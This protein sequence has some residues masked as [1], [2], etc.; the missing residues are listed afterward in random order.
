MAIECGILNRLRGTGVIKYFGT[1][2]VDEIKI[3]KLIIPKMEVEVKLVWNHIYGLYLALVFGLLAMNVWAGLAVLVAYLV[4]ES[5]GWGEWVGTLSSPEKMT[6]AKLLNV[7][8]DEEGKTFPFIFQISNFFIKEEKLEGT[9]EEKIT[10]YLRHATLALIL[11]GIYWWGMTFLPLVVF[12][13]ISV[14]HF[15]VAIIFLGI[16]FP[17]ACYLGQRWLYTGTHLKVINFSRGWENQEIIYG[18]FQGL[19]IWITIGVIL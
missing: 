7:Y 16:C 1:I 6:Y 10:Q 14:I 3:W 15:L 2:I 4:G 19:V 13:V 11:R 17:I 8:T 9:V 18:L 12:G 5:K